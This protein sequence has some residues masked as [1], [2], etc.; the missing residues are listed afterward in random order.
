MPKDKRSKDKP[1][2]PA[3]SATAMAP[4]T[5]T[6]TPQPAASSSPPAWPPLKPPLP[7]TDLTIETVF[8]SQI[9]VLRNFWPRALCRSYTAFLR[10]LPLVTTP[11]KPKRGDAVRVND[12]FEVHD[13]AFAHTLWT[14]TG[15][16]EALVAGAEG[17]AGRW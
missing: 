7:V 1:P 16:R 4:A 8:P 15:L 3:S 17:E 6:S 12:R 2:K 13:A 11:G 9:V 14:Q 10:T 5:S